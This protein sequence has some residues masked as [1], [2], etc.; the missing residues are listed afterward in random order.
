MI[1]GFFTPE[2]FF[3]LN[4]PILNQS[5]LNQRKNS[6]ITQILFMFVGWVA[7]CSLG[8]YGL[9]T[10]LGEGDFFSIV[11]SL[12]SFV[13]MI[14][15]GVVLLDFFTELD[16]FNEKDLGLGLHMFEDC[17]YNI[18]HRDSF[19]DLLD[20]VKKEPSEIQPDVLKYINALLDN[21]RYS[22]SNLEAMELSQIQANFEIECR[23]QETTFVSRTEEMMRELKVLRRSLL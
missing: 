14:A 23:K 16:L 7:L 1:I 10:Y 2:Y 22:V 15:S 9:F 19:R 20:K 12:L 18:Y 8:I 13:A 3:R 21:E 11:M 4:R 6:Y 5:E 17:D